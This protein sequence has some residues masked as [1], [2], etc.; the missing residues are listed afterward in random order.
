MK[1]TVII[2]T[3][4]PGPVFAPVLEMVR[5]QICPW[6]YEVLVIDSGSDDG[7]VELVAATDGVRLISIP[8]E[9]FGHGKTRNLAIKNSFGEFC[10]LLTHDAMPVDRH[11]LKNLVY[12]VEQ[13][14]CIAGAFGRH[15][16][17]DSANVFTKRDLKTHFQGFLAHPLVVAKDTDLARYEH[18]LGWRQFL[19]FYSDNNS[20]LRKSV[21][22]DIPYPDVEFAEDQIWAKNIIEA[23]YKKAYAADAVVYH[24]HDYRLFERLQRSFDEANAFRVLFGYRLCPTFKQ[25]LTSAYG[26]AKRDWDYG[27]AHGISLQAI[28]RQVLD[29]V[30]LVTGHLLGAKAEHMPNMLKTFLSRDRRLMNQLGGNRK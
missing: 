5:A 9:E 19:H 15:V 26:L 25:L 12:A 11:W 29:Q 3:K 2:P 6:D 7:T 22:R 16:A 4:N 13:D 8:A 1:A 27:R 30:A 14:E 17:Y 23:G 10:A 18:D 28:A 24:S 20:C 21:W